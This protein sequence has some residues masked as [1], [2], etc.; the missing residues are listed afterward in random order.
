MRRK[1]LGLAAFG[2][3]AAGGLA[4]GWLGERKVMRGALPG[5]DP[6]WD[7][8][9]RPL[10]GRRVSVESFDGTVLAADVIGD[11]DAPTLVFVHGFAL[12][13]LVWH[14][15]RR[16]LSD[17]FRLVLYDQRGH[18]ESERAASGDYSIAAL[19]RD[20]AAVIE[21][22]VP[23]GRQVVLVG[24]SLGGMTLLSFTDQFP[25]AIGERVAGGV[26][27]DTSGSDILT[28]AV[29]SSGLAAVET[30][31]TQVV[32][33]T[34]NAL[35]KGSRWA[36]R[37]YAASNDLTFL[38]T[39]GFGLNRHATPAQVAFIEQLVLGVPTEV[40][41]ALG[42]LFTS[43]DLRDAARLFLAP[44]LVV[45]GSK[46]R[47]TPPGSARKLAELLPSSELVEIPGVGHTSFLEA[48]ADVNTRL[49]AFAHAALD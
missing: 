36:D 3:A 13:Q 20:L 6:E 12:S 39:R 19:G 34:L 18:A 7:E 4:L 31:Q 35:S 11:D 30:L 42:P 45:V 17:T 22:T 26:F 48:H 37:A 21:A 8:L 40:I 14:Y 10:R 9:R 23:A 1:A 27:I 49:R 38:L 28:G 43:L 24:H 29:V 2:A 41:A 44:A 16:D 25:E 47:M 32:T 33:R 46:D 15:Q 5:A